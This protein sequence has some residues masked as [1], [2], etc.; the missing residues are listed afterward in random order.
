[1]FLLR[2]INTCVWLGWIL[3]PFLKTL[4]PVYRI[5]T[6]IIHGYVLYVIYTT[7]MGTCLLL[8][9]FALL[10]FTDNNVFYE[11]EFVATPSWAGV[12]AP[13]F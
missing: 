12:S 10:W 9:L 2:V 1:M 8:L 11:L 7:H 5:S 4:I 3:A 6:I 13:F